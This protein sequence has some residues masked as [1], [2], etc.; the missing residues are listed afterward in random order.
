MN[1]DKIK[2]LFTG[3]FKNSSSVN[4][5]GESK[6][7]VA[8]TNKSEVNVADTTNTKT[9]A[10]AAADPSVPTG[11]TLEELLQRAVNEIPECLAAGYIDLE[12]GMLLAVKTVKSHP[13]EVMDMLAAATADLFQGEN[14]LAIET[15][16]KKSRGIEDE[17][18]H[19]FQEILILSNN[20]LH[21]FLR[22]NK[23]N[24]YIVTFV[25]RKSVNQGIVLTKARRILPLLEAAL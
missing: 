25:C 9:Q 3:I 7:I 14:V 21:V 6:N 16:F 10:E 19:Y 22:G 11:E 1:I 5:G 2:T 17:N 24:N 15:T 4:I 13:M 18:L 12:T 20:L 23:Y 8:S